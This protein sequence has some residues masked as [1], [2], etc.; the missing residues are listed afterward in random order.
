VIIGLFV[1]LMV[2]N[3]TFKR[4][5]FIFVWYGRFLVWLVLWCLIPL[6]TIYQLY[7]GGLFYWWRKPKHPEKTA[8]LSLITENLYH[9]MLYT[10]PWSRLELTASLVISTDCIG[11]CKSNYHTITAMTDI[12][13]CNLQ[14]WLLVIWNIRPNTFC[15]DWYWLY[16]C[17]IKG[18]NAVNICVIMSVF[19]K[20]SY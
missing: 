10:L 1:C 8:D 13:L 2:L 17:S 20:Q 15:D 19:S 9:I 18:V 7:L 4:C 14:K 12:F 16:R 3:A 11:S 6:S 5:N